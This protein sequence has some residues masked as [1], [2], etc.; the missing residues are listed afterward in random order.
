MI[1]HNDVIFNDSLSSAEDPYAGLTILEI[2]RLNYPKWAHQIAGMT[3]LFIGMF[4]F[5][6]NCLVLYTFYKSKHLRTATNI[7]IIGLSMSDMCM[8]M[9]GNPLASTSALNGGW[10]AGT[11]MCYW[12]GFVVYTFGLASLYLLTAVSFDRYVVIAKPLKAA[13]ITKRVAVL[14][15]VSCYLLG[16]LWSIPPFFGWGKYGLEAPGVFCGLLWETPSAANQSY[17][18]T[19][20]LACFIIPVGVMMFSYYCVFMTVS[21]EHAC[22]FPIYKCTCIYFNTMCSVIK[23]MM[24]WEAI[25][26]NS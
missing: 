3:L 22:I 16:M 21:N 1:T 26:F 10:F 17:I 14:S 18:F 7:F 19:I 2:K 25:P 6:E 9:L 8:V 13:L 4:G 12:E 15:V 20:F 11:F 5:V 24:A 23:T